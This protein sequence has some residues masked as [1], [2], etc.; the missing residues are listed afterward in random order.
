MTT[1]NSALDCGDGHNLASHQMASLVAA[2]GAD[3]VIAA[4]RKRPQRSIGD[5]TVDGQRTTA[6]SKRT[7]DARKRE[8][9]ALVKRVRRPELGCGSRGCKPADSGRF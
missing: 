3:R 8:K 6:G 4:N 2:L 5:G 1:I 9:R 7:E